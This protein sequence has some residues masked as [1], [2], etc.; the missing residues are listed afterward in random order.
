M[1]VTSF[2]VP[3]KSLLLQP[4]V[5]MK[6]LS[7]RAVA[8]AS[9]PESEIAKATMGASANEALERLTDTSI[10]YLCNRSTLANIRR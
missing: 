1:L 4:M 5:L 8:F 3:S 6:G 10:N 2:V 9:G 7:M